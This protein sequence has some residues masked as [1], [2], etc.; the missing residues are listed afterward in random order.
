MRAIASRRTAVCLWLL[1]TPCSF[2]A[3]LA[4]AQSAGGSVHDHALRADAALRAGQPEKAIPE[5][6]AIVRLE[7]TNID[8]QANLG[9]LLYFQQNFSSATE[10]LRAAVQL[11]PELYKQRAL[12]GLSEMQLGQR[13]AA[14]D[15]LHAALEHLDEPKF[16]KQVGLSLVELQTAK[17]NLSA[18]TATAQ[19]LRSKAPEDAE[20]LYACY[21]TA[22][23]LAGDS[24]LSLSLA[25]PES[26][27]M[28]Q[29]IAHELL[30]VRDITGAIASLRRAVAADPKLAGLHFELAEALHVSPNTADRE[31][32]TAEYRLAVQLNPQDAQ[33]KT[34][35]ADLLSDNS[36]WK[37]AGALYESAL[38]LDPANADAAIGL[39]RVASETG[40]DAKAVPLLQQAIAEDPSNM[41]AH[42]RLSSVYRKL[43]RTEDAR[44]EIAT[45]QKLRDVKDKL[46][47]TYSTMKLQT[48]GSEDP[49]TSPNGMSH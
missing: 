33:A 35:L 23:D 11:Q 18:A 21:R 9:A 24:L 30:R 29:A 32:A 40:D 14:A 22:T 28:H 49:A 8:A 10:H 25:A 19:Y 15:D 31:Q 47:Q 16:R 26:A 34:R 6:E 48:P 5:F 36:A 3:A 4:Q 42:F 13:D 7:P 27:Q 41:L 12:L 44:R 45:Y 1:L 20:I 46:R 17:Q 43:H 38:K 39:A 2:A 37:D